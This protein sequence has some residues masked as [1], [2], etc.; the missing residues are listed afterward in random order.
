VHADVDVVDDDY[1]QLAQAAAMAAMA[2]AEH[3]GREA[4]ATM[5]ETHHQQAAS[6]HAWLAAMASKRCQ[7]QA[8]KQKQHHAQAI[9]TVGVDQQEEGHSVEVEEEEEEEEVSDQTRQIFNFFISLLL[10]MDMLGTWLTWID[11]AKEGCVEHAK[12]GQVQLIT[13]DLKQAHVKHAT[14]DLEQPHIEHAVE[15][16]E[17]PHVK[18]AVEDLEQAHIEHATEDIDLKVKPC[19][20]R[21]PSRV[22]RPARAT[23]KGQVFSSASLMWRTIGL[24]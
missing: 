5:V 24:P 19:L 7:W 22:Q 18:H 16:L 21:R 20:R 3:E 4:K 23:F 13:E 9:V 1:D 11:P 14:E 2:D 12:P 15:D 8:I 10:I 17:Q 6:M